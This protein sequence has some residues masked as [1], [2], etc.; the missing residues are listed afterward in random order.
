MLEACGV[1]YSAGPKPLLVEVNIAA[2]PG[3]VTVL[4]GPNGAGK[5]TL[6]RILSGELKPSAGDVRLDG[7]LLNTIPP[8]YLAQ[9]RAVVPQASALAFP[10]TALEVAMLGATVPGF[11]LDDT[12]S[13][14]AA[15][16]TLGTLGM[17]DVADRP[18]AFLSGGERQRVHI[19][20]ALVQLACAPPLK[21][22]RV[23]LLDE[24][25]S[26]LDLAHQ[27]AVL[28]VMSKQA[29]AQTAV[30]AVLHDLNLAAAVA[31]ELVLLSQG[32]VARRGTPE[33]V[34]KD[35]ILSAVYGCPLSVGRIPQNG[36]PFLL[37]P[38]LF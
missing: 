16:T 14:C 29:S 36:K 15:E 10:F 19:A 3:S 23:L 31:D 25:T 20:R 11:Q 21:G 34:L 6:L 4:I 37:P 22:T 33:T 2:R 27:A 1:S 5:S 7:E 13:R 9:R 24:P 18:Y 8:G 30:I 12:Q 32:R 17:S 26:S 38:A 28:D 35:D